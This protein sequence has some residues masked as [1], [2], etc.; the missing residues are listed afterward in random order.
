MKAYEQLQQLILV[1]NKEEKRK[2][3]KRLLEQ[4]EIYSRQKT[5]KLFELIDDNK[6]SSRLLTYRALYDKDG[7]NQSF[8][9]LCLRLKEKIY[10]VILA[11]SSILSNQAAERTLKIF[12]LR[13]KINLIDL[14]VFKGYRFNIINELNSIIKSS[15]E[16]EVYDVELS[17]LSTKFRL[18]FLKGNKQLNNKIMKS[19]SMVQEEW[20][21]FNEAQVIFTEINS[22]INK[23]N[24][25]EDYKIDLE[26]AITSFNNYLKKSSSPTI[27]YFKLFLEMD[28]AQK[29]ENY[30]LADKLLL[31]QY[32][33]IRGFKSVY[34]ITREFNCTLNYADNFI[35]LN[36]YS[37]ALE[38]TARTK[39]LM[40]NHQLNF[41]LALELELLALIYWGKVER[42]LPLSEKLQQLSYKLNNEYLL[43][44]R[45]LMI[46]NLHFINRN[47]QKVIE[48]L[49]ESREIDRDK[50]G[51]N[52]IRRL[53]TI[54]CKIE[55]N[56]LDSLEL[57]IQNMDKYI[58]RMMKS[59]YIQPRYLI[60]FRILR[61][62]INDNFDYKKVY[63]SR[64]KQFDL[65]YSGQ[66]EYKWKI[67]SPELVIF[68]EWFLSKVEK[69]HYNHAEVMNK[70]AAH[71]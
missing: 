66:K 59:K 42:A 13:K 56:D 3:K 50:E 41:S 21:M 52:I 23:S 16:F 49:T 29:N 28:R 22:K 11:K 24:E 27:L 14:L 36:N 39:V 2:L 48:L 20:R 45:L 61:K 46:L 68:E 15:H 71:I 60:I 4:S 6:A 9:K 44:R 64:K 26:S 1:L 62:L 19:I 55:L 53:M 47:F 35:Q 30:F 57:N 10:E 17:A 37:K 8:S 34:N 31:E 43:S 63:S 7:Q 18:V 5:L 54:L 67:K 51:L 58:K 25:F 69:S 40:Q 12:E 33:T 70:R 38:Y 32:N 65:L